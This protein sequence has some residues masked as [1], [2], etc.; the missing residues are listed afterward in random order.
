MAK[1]IESFEPIINKNSRVLILGTIPGPKSLERKQYYANERNQFW[2]IIY[3]VLGEE[4]HCDY[5]ERIEFLKRIGIA[6]WDVLQSCERKGASDSK[7]KHEKPNDF[8]GLLWTYPKL[9]CLVFNGNKARDLFNKH[10]GHSLKR[11]D[12][13]ALPS[14]SPANTMPFG[15]KVKAWESIKD[16]L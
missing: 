2:R 14:S 9:R 7:I 4:P 12:L 16:C 1:V 5:V 8:E 11:M 15:Q 13:E 10:V 3:H 6:L